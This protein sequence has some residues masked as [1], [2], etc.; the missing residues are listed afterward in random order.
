MLC[1]TAL[2]TG[3]RLGEL[4]ALTWGD[5][6]LLDGHIRVRR[7]YTN[8]VLGPTKNRQVRTVDIIPELVKALGAWWGEQGKP[9]ESV[10]V[11][12]RED[13]GGYIESWMAI[14]R[15]RKAMVE[16]GVPVVGKTTPA[17]RG[18]HSFRHTYAKVALEQG[19]ELYHLSRHLGH[20]SQAVTD[21]TY[22][23]WGRKAAKAQTAK[24]AGAFSV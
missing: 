19:T 22:G 15:L 7:S 23:H 13:T 11:F 14:Y 17:K 12:Q 9:D 18:F 10:L 8:G 2:K 3:M 24:L 1:L 6:D 5:I 4:I 21:L 16:A 20:S